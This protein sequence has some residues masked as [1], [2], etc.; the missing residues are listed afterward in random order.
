MK[1]PQRWVV[2]GFAVAATLP[3]AA[4]A[5]HAADI[6][7]VPSAITDSLLHSEDLGG[8]TVVEGGPSGGHT[9]MPKPCRHSMPG[10]QILAGRAMH[11]VL[12]S[13]HLIYQGV[14]RYQSAAFATA[15]AQ[16]A[17]QEVLDCTTGPFGRRTY[18]I[19]DTG[20]LGSDSVLVAHNWNRIGRSD[21]YAI[22]PVG[23]LLIV[24]L[25]TGSRRDRGDLATVS[26]LGARAV[27]RASGGLYGLGSYDDLDNN[28]GGLGSLG[29][30]DASG[31]TDQSGGTDPISLDPVVTPTVTVSPAATSDGGGLGIGTGTGDTSALDPTVSPTVT[32]TVTP[33]ATATTTTT[34]GGLGSQDPNN[35]L[36]LD[37]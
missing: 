25:D 9:L 15:V 21:T 13:G 18:E 36:T 4:S 6:T 23:D 3:C 30:L 2:A 34:D 31:V 10:P 37:P 11:A 7:Q 12:P 14:I 19:A 20:T 29:G 1:F 17:R 35:P 8:A 32:V 33:T 22:A 24:V 27:R 26:T 16:R 5:A 28:T